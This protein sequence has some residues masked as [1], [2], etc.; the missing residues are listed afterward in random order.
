MTATTRCAAPRALLAQPFAWADARPRRAPPP[1]PTL[2]MRGSRRSPIV[3]IR[4]S[5][6]WSGPRSGRRTS[7]ASSCRAQ[8]GGLRRLTTGECCRREEVEVREGDQSG[9]GSA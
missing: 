5:S 9:C 3:S 2:R 8:A 7:C 6:C 4:S 1:H